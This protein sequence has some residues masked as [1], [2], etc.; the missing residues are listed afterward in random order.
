VLLRHRVR[1]EEEV[2]VS[3]L[4][5]LLHFVDRNPHATKTRNQTLT[6]SAPSHQRH[7]LSPLV[8][9]LVVGGCT[10]CVFPF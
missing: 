6:P 4:L 9:L 8:A 10:G 7:G 1:S 5:A 2:L 3:A